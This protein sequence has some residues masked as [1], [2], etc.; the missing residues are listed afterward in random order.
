[1]SPGDRILNEIITTPRPLY[2]AEAVTV[3]EALSAK[4]WNPTR[5]AL[6]DTEEAVLR[7]AGLAIPMDRHLASLESHMLKRVSD[8][9]WGEKAADGSFQRIPSPQE[10]LRDVQRM[11]LQGRGPILWERRA[12]GALVL[13]IWQTDPGGGDLADSI[14]AQRRGKNAR[15]QFLVVYSLQHGSFTTAMFKKQQ[16]KAHSESTAT[17]WLV[18]PP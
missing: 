6:S 14:P 2:D 10:F 15:G 4:P 7:A 9:Q 18:S 8:G 13:Q 12:D 17:Q 1:M 11:V 5:N 3:R 16:P